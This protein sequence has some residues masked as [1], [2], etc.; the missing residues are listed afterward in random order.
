MTDP[1]RN[2]F[3]TQSAAARY[4]AG[5]PF[6]HEMAVRMFRDRVG[7]N[8][9]L[10]WACDVGCGTGLSTIAVASIADRVIGLDISPDMLALAPRDPKVRYALAR[11]EELPLA[12]ASVDLMT[13]SCVF[14]WLD[15]PRF[16]AEARRTIRPGGWLVFIGHGFAGRMAECDAFRTWAWEVYPRHYPAANRGATS[17]DIAKRVPAGFALSFNEKFEHSLPMTRRQVVAYLLTQSNVIAKVEQGSESIEQ[18][19]SWLTSEIAAFFTAAGCA[20][21]DQTGEFAFHGHV[22]CLERSDDRGR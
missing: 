20:G 14:H 10:D 19:E 3:D 5:R 1:L 13:L 16:L 4:A 6:F 18:V 12:D 15:Q 7:L 22:T 11:A 17:Y 9:P 21:D 8:R 2:P